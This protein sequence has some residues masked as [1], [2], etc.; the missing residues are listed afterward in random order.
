MAKKESTFLNMTLTLFVITAVA[1]VAL[2]SVYNLT[3][4]PIEQVKKQKLQTAIGIVVP[5]ASKGKF[6]DFEVIET[7][8]ADGE[9]PIT[10]YKVI[11]DGGFV[12]MAIKSFSMKGFSGYIS[13]MVGF[14]ENGNIIDS[15]VLEHK[16]T[17]G[18]GD[19][20]DKKVNPWNN[21]FIGKNPTEFVLK[22]KKDG[23]S[24]DA[25]TAATITSRAYCDA[26]Q[27]AYDTYMKYLQESVTEIDEFP[28]NE[29]DENDENIVE[30]NDGGNE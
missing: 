29:V 30:P 7:Q 27:R 6:D 17:P 28:V 22:V 2:A 13:V 14:D 12:G 9:G 21:Q 20:T 8:S 24:V 19:K 23:G 25:I 4:E 15:N 18:L 3:K 16:E 10:M 1:A 5:D 26:V 11:V